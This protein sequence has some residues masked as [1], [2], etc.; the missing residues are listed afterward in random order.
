MIFWFLHCWL[1]LVIKIKNR[2]AAFNRCAAK[3]TGRCGSVI[4]YKPFLVAGSIAAGLHKIGGFQQR[5][6]PGICIGPQIWVMQPC[7]KGL[8]EQCFEV[9]AGYSIR[10]FADISP[11]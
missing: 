4:K 5:L 6:I 2:Q 11:G 1:E 8:V 9:G 10:K 7:Y 3:R